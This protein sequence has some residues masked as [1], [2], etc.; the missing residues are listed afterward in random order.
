M[1]PEYYFHPKLNL[2]VRLIA[3]L[4]SRLVKY[5]VATRI[6]AHRLAIAAGYVD[7]LSACYIPVLQSSTARSVDLGDLEAPLA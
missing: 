5:D 4:G 6:L 1:R 7:R 3:L 2:A